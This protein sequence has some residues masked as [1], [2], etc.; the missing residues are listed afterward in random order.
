MFLKLFIPYL[1][2]LFIITA[3]DIFYK[4]EIWPEFIKTS[5][6]FRL[7]GF[8]TPELKSSEL[9]WEFSFEDA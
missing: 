2:P 8:I 6:L 4:P 9:F 3:L 5:G 7:I 1:E